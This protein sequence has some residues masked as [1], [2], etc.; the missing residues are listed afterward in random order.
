MFT[1]C[2]LPELSDS[3]P[4]LPACFPSLA[5]VSHCS[6]AELAPAAPVPSSSITTVVGVGRAAL[7]S[8]SEDELRQAFDARRLVHRYV[9]PGD[10]AYSLEVKSPLPGIRQRT[11][12]NRRRALAQ[13]I[14]KHDKE[15][16][17]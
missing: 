15:S 11:K 14:S 2:R 9:A 13:M 5:A 7:L 10:G 8:C 12:E 17:R 16:S 4:E 6:Q 3:I 1:A